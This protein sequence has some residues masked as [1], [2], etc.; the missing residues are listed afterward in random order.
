MRN[1]WYTK[2]RKR[3]KETFFVRIFH[4]RACERKSPYI[5]GGPEKA[6]KVPKKI[7][8]GRYNDMTTL[9]GWGTT[10]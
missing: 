8:I 6:V 3:K 2:A 4:E 5:A 7:H 10:Q 1:L 9:H